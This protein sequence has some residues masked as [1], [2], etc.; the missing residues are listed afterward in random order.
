MPRIRA[1]N[2]EA[3]KALTRRQILETAEELFLELGYT[4]TSFADI[5]AEI[6]VGRTTLYEYFGDKEE[7]LVE[8]VRDSLPPLVDSIVDGIPA[9]LDAGQR[10]GELVVRHLEFIC[11]ESNVGTLIMRE[12]PLL[13]PETQE[14][15]REAHS[16][17]ESTLVAIVSEGVA[18]GRFRPVDPELAGELV[19]SIVMSTA[20]GLLRSSDPKGRLHETSDVMLDFL[21][22]GLGAA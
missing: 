10:L 5:A 8:L 15:I 3:H 11:D 4:D 19:N 9:G 16:R 13:T 7:I 12:T 20:R 18:D 14:R 1:D 21:S 22:H 2:I 6:G 17:L